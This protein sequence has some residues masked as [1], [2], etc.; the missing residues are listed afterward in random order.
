MFSKLADE[1]LL[2][3]RSALV[4][5]PELGIKCCLGTH[6][7][8]T[9]AIEIVADKEVRL[10]IDIVTLVTIYDIGVADAVVE[11]FGLL[12][13]AQS[14]ID[15]LHLRIEKDKSRL[16]QESSFLRKEG[17]QIIM[18]TVLPT[19]LEH[20]INYLERLLIWIDKHC[21][22]LPC[23]HL[24][25]QDAER[26]QKNEE[27]EKLV[28]ASFAETALIA[29]E[30]GRILYSDDMVYRQFSQA[31]IGVA[32]IWTQEILRECQ[33]RNLLNSTQY[34]GSLIK[35]VALNYQ[36]VSIDDDVLIEAARQAEWLNSSPLKGLLRYLGSEQNRTLIIVGDS[37]EEDAIVS[38]IDVL[39]GFIYKLWTQ[40][41]S[42]QRRDE[43][44]LFAVRALLRGRRKHSLILKRLDVKLGKR[45]YWLPIDYQYLSNSDQFSTFYLCKTDLVACSL[46]FLFLVM[47]G[48]YDHYFA[49]V[50]R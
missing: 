45:F 22:I 46:V 3:T 36:Y 43:I 7:E 17:E 32:G 18:Q 13:V 42:S 5:N 14:T 30:D 35:L 48:S 49:W 39:A 8:R 21:Q 16:T 11:A 9:Q 2:V 10:I 19:E 38:S 25:S 50:Q 20:N 28:G 26:R 6:Q 47:L 37:L 23:D 29:S 44:V 40:D 12:G 15:L 33:K 1:D 27:F 4:Q 34:S 31:Q 24:L 41:I